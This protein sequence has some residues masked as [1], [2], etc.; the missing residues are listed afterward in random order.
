[1]M[2]K[3]VSTMSVEMP[4]DAVV[5]WWRKY[6]KERTA[7]GLSKAEQAIDRAMRQKHW[8]SATISQTRKIKD[9]RT[10]QAHHIEFH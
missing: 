1:M 9:G 8:K 5:K 10:K 2:I 6:R 7:D 3:F 4:R